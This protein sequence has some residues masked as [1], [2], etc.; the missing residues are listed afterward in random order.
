MLDVPRELVTFLAEL[1]ATERRDRG[2]LRTRP[3]ARPET[4]ANRL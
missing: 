2:G 4:F 1:L 3:T